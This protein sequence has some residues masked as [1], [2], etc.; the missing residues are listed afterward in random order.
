MIQILPETNESINGRFT[1]LFRAED[2]WAEDYSGNYL[3]GEEELE[4]F[5]GEDSFAA[6]MDLSAYAEV[7]GGM[8]LNLT[9]TAGN[10]GELIPELFFQP[11]S[12]IP[13]VQI[14]I[15]ED[16]FLVTTDF[17]VSGTIFDDD[18]VQSIEYRIDDGEFISIEGGNSFAIPVAYK[19]LADNEH[20]MDIKAVDL[21]GVESVPI[22]LNFKVSLDVPE[23]RV[24]LPLI[25]ESNRGIISLSGTATDANGVGSV[26]LS[27]DNGNSF[28]QARG[29]GEWTYEL[30]TRVLVDGNYM[31]L[32][33]VQDLYGVS[34][35]YSSLLTIDNTP[36]VVQLSNPP[37]G[38]GVSDE[39]TFQMRIS[40]EIGVETLTY[41]L[42][43][44]G[45]IEVSKEAESVLEASSEEAFV[46][47]LPLAGVNSLEGSLA[48]SDVVIQTIDL[49]EL[50]PGR[51][52]LS[53]FAY[54]D[55]GNETVVSRNILRKDLSK[56]SVPAIL[57]PFQGTV[58]HGPF[59]L[60][61]RVEG[62]LIP[63][64]V[65]LYKNG[66]PFDVLQTDLSG[67]F[68]RNML[69]E[70]LESG[71]LEMQIV[72]EDQEGHETRSSLLYIDYSPMG[73]WI[74]IE[75]IRTVITRLT[76]PG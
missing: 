74:Q 28:H 36:P 64:T 33:K 21:W 30:D 75:S 62:D 52:N 16:N 27:V 18:G 61:G 43:P 71:A 63:E 34:A 23:A 8:S 29:T 44:L 70:E 7:P 20:T 67:Y 69:P 48:V 47:N 32:I 56:K 10:T 19:E 53:V 35:V 38:M 60:E 49:R 45:D 3:L 2:E 11:Q 51:Y 26:F 4:T 15:P 1:F 72:L 73:P 65:T 31:V 25:G 40:D 76:V 46:E 58:I 37:D 22:T 59:V 66:M 24:T 14:Q 17:N 54:D 6:A 12:D 50:L 42:R 9:D 55:A 68:Y 13:E 57:F 39:L 5:Y 41:L